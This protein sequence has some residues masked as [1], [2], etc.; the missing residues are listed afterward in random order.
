MSN[1]N[2]S[3]FTINLNKPVLLVDGSPHPADKLH[4][5]LCELCAFGR[6]EGSALKFYG[7]AQSLHRGEPITVTVE[8][9][10]LLIAEVNRS[11]IVNFAKAQ[12]E[13]ELRQQTAPP[14]A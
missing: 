8:E 1:T 3:Q 10:D 5:V 14:V 2:N 9:R 11:Q 4:T 12:L 7:W 6:R 13:I